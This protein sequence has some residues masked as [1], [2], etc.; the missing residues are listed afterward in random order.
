MWWYH[1]IFMLTLFEVNTLNALKLGT[2]QHSSEFPLLSLNCGLGSQE[3]V[4]KCTLKVEYIRALKYKIAILRLSASWRV[5]VN[6]ERV[7][8]MA[9]EPLRSD[10]KPLNGS[11]VHNSYGLCIATSFPRSLPISRLCGMNHSTLFYS[12]SSALCPSKYL[13]AFYHSAQ[14]SSNGSGPFQFDE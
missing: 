14:I 11:M 8:A 13:T 5:P 12:I 1:G 10:R 9:G 4:S 2:H 3:I 7:L 6:V